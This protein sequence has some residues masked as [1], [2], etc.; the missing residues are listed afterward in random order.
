MR[1][2][3]WGD[4][5]LR[6]EQRE[7]T[8]R[9]DGKQAESGRE[10]AKRLVLVGSGAV[11]FRSV[12]V[13]TRSGLQAEDERTVAVAPRRS[14]LDAVDVGLGAGMASEAENVPLLTAAIRIPTP[15]RRIQP[16]ARLADLILTAVGKDPAGND[17]QRVV[18]ANTLALEPRSAWRER[19]GPP[20]SKFVDLTGVQVVKVEY[21]AQTGEPAALRLAKNGQQ[22]TVRV[23][24]P[25]LRQGL[26]RIDLQAQ[27]LVFQVQGD[28]LCAVV[29]LL[30][31]A[32]AEVAA[33][34]LG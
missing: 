16:G 12:Q 28:E 14:R 34:G 31:V 6:V 9:S 18:R 7:S 23:T 32:R 17:F 25:R 1:V 2:W 20:P 19:L 10:E 11:A 13:E 33:V 29:V 27:K 21:S 26:L 24:E 5:D 3:T 30:D 8:A 15:Q 22:R 4:L